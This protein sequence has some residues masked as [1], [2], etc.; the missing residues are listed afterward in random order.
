MIEF[1][2]EQ[3][4][5]KAAE[6]IYR[7]MGYTSIVDV[8]AILTARAFQEG[9]RPGSAAGDMLQNVSMALRVIGEGELA[10]SV[11]KLG[12]DYRLAVATAVIARGAQAVDGAA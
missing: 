10:D 12:S 11:D 7:Q 5:F 3:E 8:G 6:V 1:N 9:G 2:Y 4:V